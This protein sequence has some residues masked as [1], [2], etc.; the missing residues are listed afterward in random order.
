MTAVNINKKS[1]VELLALFIDHTLSDAM[2]I[3]LRCWVR[4]GLQCY[5]DNDGLLSIDECLGLSGD[6][7]TKAVREYN[8]LKRN[9]YLQLALNEIE[10][11]TTTQKIIKL[12]REIIL[13]ARNSRRTSSNINKTRYYLSQAEKHKEI[14]KTLNYLKKILN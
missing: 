7:T 2:P 13:H 5:I 4:G 11:Q 8:R 3:R 10:A 6:G 12:H 9:E 14:P 1:E